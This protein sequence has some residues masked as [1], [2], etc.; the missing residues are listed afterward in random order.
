MQ[1]C[2]HKNWGHFLGEKIP[3]KLRKLTKSHHTAFQE[4]STLNGKQ[5]KYFLYN[6][7]K[8]VK[9][10]KMAGTRKTFNKEM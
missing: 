7:Q 9:E 6:A 1:S 8:C 10:Y 2:T 3:R 4:I 5:I